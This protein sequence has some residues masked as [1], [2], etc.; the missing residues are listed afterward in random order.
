[1]PRMVTL[2]RVL[3]LA[4]L[5]G[6]VSTPPSTPAPH[7]YYFDCD[8]PPGRF[9]EWNR[10]VD[11]KEVQISGAV[12]VVEPRDDPKWSPIAQVLITGKDKDNPSTLGFTVGLTMAVDLRASDLVQIFLKKSGGPVWG[13]AV[14]S[15]TWRRAPIQFTLR[16]THSG[17]LAASAA[18][19]SRSVQVNGFDL[20]KLALSC[21]TG[22][23]KFKNVSVD[24]KK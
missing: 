13:D 10:T 23:F 8:V 19:T 16:F 4:V 1:M 7:T 6:C 17:E 22:Q 3:L 5:A 2:F 15:T 20:K 14:L 11:G 24:V 18:G 9:S 21:G 12:E